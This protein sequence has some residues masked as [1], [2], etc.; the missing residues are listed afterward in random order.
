MAALVLLLRD[1]CGA[2]RL[3]CRYVVALGRIAM[4]K[5]LAAAALALLVTAAGNNDTTASGTPGTNLAVAPPAPT[6]PT[7][8]PAATN[9]TVAATPDVTGGGATNEA[10]GGARLAGTP[11]HALSAE[12]A[13]RAGTKLRPSAR[14]VRC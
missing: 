12:T 6:A 2:S 7:T 14:R 11:P 8:A 4:P 9:A 1:L 13:A 5:R 3:L 10:T